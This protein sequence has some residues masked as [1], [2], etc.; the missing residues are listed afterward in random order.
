MP[1]PGRGQVAGGL[2]VEIGPDHA[3]SAPDL[4]HDA[5]EWIVGPD[6]APDSATP[7]LTILHENDHTWITP[8]SPELS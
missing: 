1:Q 5:F 2:V 3:G 8:L 4:A 6:A 7:T